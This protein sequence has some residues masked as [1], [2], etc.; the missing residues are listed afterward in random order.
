VKIGS[1]ERRGKNSYR[2]IV[3]GG[4][5]TNGERIVYKK[6]IKANTRREAQIALAAFVAE[7]KAPGYQDPQNMAFWEYSEIWLASHAERELQ[8]KT[9]AGYRSILEKR[10]L[11]YFGKMRIADI[12]PLDINQFYIQMEKLA[13][14]PNSRSKGRLSK[15]T[16]HHYH[17]LLNKMM[18]DAVKMGIL[19]E[20]P[21][22][23]CTAPRPKARKIEFEENPLNVLLAAIQKE[24]LRY[25]ALLL[26]TLGTGMRLGEVTGLEWKH[27]DFEKKIIHIVQS[28]QYLPESGVVCKEPKSTSSRRSIAAPEDVLL[29]LARYR[30][31]QEGYP[32]LKDA[33]DWVFRQPDGGHMKPNLLS[34]WFGRFRRR[35]ELPEMRFHDLRHLSATLSLQ[36][37][38]SPTNVAA[39]LGHS[40][41]STTMDIYS[42]ALRSVDKEAAEKLNSVLKLPTAKEESR[43]IEQEAS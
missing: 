16:I 41:T 30:E 43:T 42:H 8:P 35:R 5:D 40:K 33:P 9:I 14:V 31:E 36:Q 24:E 27:V 19:K 15:R 10:L 2:L 22:E 20:N 11:P 28:A 17:T 23:R 38:I 25:Q 1:V 37:G 32:K 26:L 39:R 3:S 7:V 18:V 29:I 6:T 13:T 4:T 34:G 12:N 21:V